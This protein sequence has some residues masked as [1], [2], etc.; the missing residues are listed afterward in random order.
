MSGRLIFNLLLLGVAAYFVWA[1]TGYDVQ[2]RR[3]PIMIG[4]L[5]LML[6]A[7]VT[8][9]E[10]VKPVTEPPLLEGAEELP[11]DEGRRVAVMTAWMV[12]FFVLFTVF[13]TLIA[14]A[15][16]IFLFLVAARALRWWGALAIALGLSASI[17]IVF[18]KALR[19]E[20]YP[21]LLF[22]GTLPAL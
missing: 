7:W 10:L 19:F 18:V 9:Q 12:G 2:G 3:I 1:A 5:V 4:V 14:T 11:P 13:G 16:F 20:L 8:F 21:G 22:G 15:A 17:W 6:Q